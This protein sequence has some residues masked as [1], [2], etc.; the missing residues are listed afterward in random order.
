MGYL[1]RRCGSRS[2]S[3]PRAFGYSEAP[4]RADGLT[5]AIGEAFQEAG[6]GIELSVY[7]ADFGQDREPVKKKS[8]KEKTVVK[9]ALKKK[10]KAKARKAA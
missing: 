1:R 7:A 2:V 5:Q 8:A 6:I 10:S 3:L 9:A 4:L